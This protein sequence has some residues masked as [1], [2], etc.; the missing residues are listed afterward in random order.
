MSPFMNGEFLGGLV[1]RVTIDAAWVCAQ[2]WLAYRW[3]INGRVEF[4]KPAKDR[5][6]SSKP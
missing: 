1:V 2:L 3:Y 4:W 6:A 5:R